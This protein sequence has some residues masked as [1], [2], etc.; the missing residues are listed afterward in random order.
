MIIRSLESK[1]FKKAENEYPFF[2]SVVDLLFLPLDKY[3]S[4]SHVFPVRK[5]WFARVK[6]N[7]ISNFLVPILQGA[8]KKLSLLH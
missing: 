3:I 5:T 7:S 4:R 8:C 1:L 6:N 2:G